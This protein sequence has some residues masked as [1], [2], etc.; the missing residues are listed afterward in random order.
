MTSLILFPLK[1]H[2][3]ELEEK[4]TSNIAWPL[5]P[6]LSGWQGVGQK[7][8]SMANLLKKQTTGR[9]YHFLLVRCRSGEKP[10]NVGAKGRHQ[11]T[12]K[13]ELQLWAEI[14]VYMLKY[15]VCICWTCKSCNQICMILY[16]YV[17]KCTHGKKRGEYNPQQNQ[18]NQIFFHCSMAAMFWLDA[19]NEIMW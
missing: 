3:H 16:I 12:R 7:G 18:N 17:Y 14:H 5:F 1:P 15:C 19:G 11:A 10:Q 4:T 13:S 9:T 8:C 2:S 6:I